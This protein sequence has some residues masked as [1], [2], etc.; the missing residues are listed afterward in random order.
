[1]RV[2]DVDPVSPQK[3]REPNH[4]ERILDAAARVTTEALDSLRLHVISQPGR[5]WIQR[6]EV[7]LESRAIV[8]LG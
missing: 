7:H 1:M 3:S 8:P 4:R 6:R 2:Q 5:D